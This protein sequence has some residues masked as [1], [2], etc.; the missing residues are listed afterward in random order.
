MF[1]PEASNFSF[2]LHKINFHPPFSIPNCRK[3]P[4]SKLGSTAKVARSRDRDG[5]EVFV[6]PKKVREL[7]LCRTYLRLIAAMDT[8]E[9]LFILHFT[10]I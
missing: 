1:T 4:F 9:S 8:M 3:G 6:A 10:W 2:R 7:V 5:G